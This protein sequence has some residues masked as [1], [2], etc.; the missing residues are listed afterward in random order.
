MTPTPSC[1]PGM[2]RPSVTTRSPAA[3]MARSTGWRLGS[4][5]REPG[6][7]PLKVRL[8]RLTWRLYWWGLWLT[9]EVL[10]GFGLVAWWRA[11]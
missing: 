5:R 1:W 4:W 8:A 2:R 11:P 6:W 9:M 10:V 3:S 7:T